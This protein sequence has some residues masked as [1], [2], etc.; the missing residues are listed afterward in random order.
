MF[1]NRNPGRLVTGLMSL[2]L[3][4]TPV[5]V[6]AYPVEDLITELPGYNEEGKKNPPTDW[7]SGYLEYRLPCMDNRLVHT[8]YMY[9]AAED[10]RHSNARDDETDDLSASTT[11]ARRAS[12]TS[13]NE[14]DGTPLIVWSNGGPG[15]SSM[16]GLFTEIGPFVLNDDSLETEAYNRTGVP[17]LFKNPSSW[18]QLGD[19]LIFDAPAPVGFSYCDNNP[20]GDGMSCGGWDDES[21]A[22]NNYH[23][24]LA[25]YQKFP[26]LKKRPLYLT[27][28]SYGGIYIPSMARKILEHNEK[29]ILNQQNNLRTDDGPEKIPLMGFAVGDACTGT[30]V[31]CGNEAAIFQL[32]FF[33]GHGQISFKTMHTVRSICT[34]EELHIPGK[35]KSPECSAVLQETLDSAGGYYEYSLYDDCTYHNGLLRKRPHWSP[36][37]KIN[38]L[39]TVEI[40][41]DIVDGALN[42][43]TCGGGEVME[44]YVRHSLVRKA[45]N[46]PEESNFFD[47]DNGEGFNYTMTERNLMPFYVD[48]AT[49]KYASKG[50]RTLVYNGDADPSVN[51]FQAENWTVSLG[52]N[53][54]EAWRPWTTDSCR[55][56]GG[57]VT[58]Y[59]GSLDFLTIRGAGHMVPTYKPE[60]TFS[61]LEAWIHNQDYPKFVPACVQP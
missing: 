9:I 7:Y 5:V 60:A 29:A 11:T 23:A 31:N 44:E 53:E 37:K 28:E 36:V 45:F 48:V 52:L 39:Q 43:Y 13:D 30:D 42:D 14:D 15:A 32:M 16:F 61:F 24:L 40:G 56:M 35:E 25:F 6:Y 20:T 46:V 12:A 27:G 2:L 21:S 38:K 22:W 55:R 1:Q 47:G 10:G 54:V 51:S 4:L 58:R 26:E 18:N 59:E 33:G 50:I 19:L 34:E 8:H 17:T 41:G 49:G 3:C 57:Y